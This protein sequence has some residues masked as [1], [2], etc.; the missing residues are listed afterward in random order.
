MGKKTQGEKRRRGKSVHCTLL[1]GVVSWLAVAGDWGC[2]RWGGAVGGFGGEGGGE[3]GEAS[4]GYSY[5]L[6][7]LLL[8]TCNTA[9]GEDGRGGQRRCEGRGEL[10]GCSYL[11]VQWGWLLF[12]L[13]CNSDAIISDGER[14]RRR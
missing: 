3:G 1:V 12:C 8:S 14:E 11:P 5:T 4:T 7:A 2:A 10:E 6:A 9:T 13:G